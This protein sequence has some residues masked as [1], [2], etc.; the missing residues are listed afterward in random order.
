MNIDDVLWK[1]LSGKESKSKLISFLF[2]PIYFIVKQQIN[3]CIMEICL[4]CIFMYSLAESDEP[5][6]SVFMCVL[7]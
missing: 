5:V 1:C 2:P 3:V 6:I 7:R 4:I